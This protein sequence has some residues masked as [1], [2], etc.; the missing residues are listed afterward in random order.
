MKSRYLFF[1][2]FVIITYSSALAQIIFDIDSLKN[3]AVD[4]TEYD[5]TMNSYLTNNASNPDDTIFEWKVISV[6]QPDDWELTICTYNICIAAPIINDT[7]NFSLKVGEKEQF[8]IGW[9][10]FETAGTGSVTVSVNSKRYPEFKDTITMQIATLVSF[11][12]ITQPDFFVYPNP[13]KDKM[14]IRFSNTNSKTI[15]IYDILGNKIFTQEIYS[16]ES[17]NLSKLTKGTYI[18]RFQG[19]SSYSKIIQKN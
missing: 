11:T 12:K 1:L 6:N 9:S 10:L 5:F 15:E 16:G 17:I 7:Y 2:F 18:I 8:K 13:V 14:T 19:L 4:R 3:N